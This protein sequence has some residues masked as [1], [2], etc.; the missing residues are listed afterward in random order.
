MSIVSGLLPSYRFCCE[1]HWRGEVWFGIWNV[2]EEALLFDYTHSFYVLLVTVLVPWFKRTLLIQWIQALSRPEIFKEDE[3]LY[4]NRI[5]T[6]KYLETL[7][8]SFRWQF[9]GG[10]GYH[11]IIITYFPP[12]AYIWSLWSVM[13][14]YIEWKFE[15]YFGKYSRD[16]KISTSMK[17]DRFFNSAVFMSRKNWSV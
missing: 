1:L 4:M 11:K 3:I 12:S 2:C 5:K 13:T 10:G 7:R 15:Q 17:T 8:I 14:L 16:L 9:D 6:E